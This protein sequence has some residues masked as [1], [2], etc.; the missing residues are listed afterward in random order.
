MH[1]PV[2]NL[3]EYGHRRDAKTLERAVIQGNF[4]RDRRDY[5]NI[6]S[7]LTEALQSK[8]EIK[9]KIAVSGDT[10]RN[11]SDDILE[12]AEAWGYQA[13]AGQ[14]EPF[15]PIHDEESHAFTLHLI[16]EGQLDIPRELSNVVVIHRG[17]SYLDYYALMQ[18]MDIVVPA[19]VNLDCAVFYYSPN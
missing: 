8:S 19:F 2:L 9:K 3:P 14:E 17:L 4:Q 10:S 11:R 12:N 5:D 16:G 1:A 13:P 7:D 15:E 18:S 6:F